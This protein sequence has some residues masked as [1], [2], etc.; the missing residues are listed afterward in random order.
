MSETQRDPVEA[1]IN[2][3]AFSA[4]EQPVLVSSHR[5]KRMTEEMRP[6]DEG[7]DGSTLTFKTLEH[8]GEFP[9]EMP[10]AIKV[11]DAEGRWCIYHPTAGIDGK[12]V[13][14]HGYDY[15]IETGGKF[16]TPLTG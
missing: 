11:I 3:L 14:S 7:M 12:I 2:R 10:M 6:Q 5:F 13:Q 8:G 4:A 15:N 16:R 9:D 1:A